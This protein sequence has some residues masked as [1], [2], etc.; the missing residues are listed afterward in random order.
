MNA[1]GTLKE[2]FLTTENRM[3]EQIAMNIK[4]LMFQTLFTFYQMH[5]QDIVHGDV[6]ESNLLVKLDKRD[7][8]SVTFYDLCISGAVAKIIDS[9]LEK[10]K[11]GS[12]NNVS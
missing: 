12:N 3:A 11:K 10:K 5:A 9:K 6:Y 1:I 2:A 4:S 8:E 7:D